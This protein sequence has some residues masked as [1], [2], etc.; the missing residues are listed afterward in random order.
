MGFKINAMKTKHIRFTRN[1]NLNLDNHEINC[2]L[3]ETVTPK[4][5]GVYFDTKLKLNEQIM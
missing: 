3:I 4:Y 5:L 1:Q 2:F